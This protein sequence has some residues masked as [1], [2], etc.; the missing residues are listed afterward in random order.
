M[1]TRV[2]KDAVELSREF[3]VLRR[4]ERVTDRGVVWPFGYDKYP[5][6]LLITFDGQQL[7]GLRARDE[8]QQKDL[9]EGFEFSVEPPPGLI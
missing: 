7:L 1:I 8:A 2:C 6:L 9:F 3:D 5:C 4:L